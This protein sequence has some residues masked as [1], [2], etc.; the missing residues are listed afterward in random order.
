MKVKEFIKWADEIKAKYGDLFRDGLR[1]HSFP[2]EVY[3]WKEMAMDREGNL[4]F[5]AGDHG[6]SNPEHVVCVVNGVCYSTEH[7]N[8][9]FQGACRTISEYRDTADVIVKVSHGKKV[10]AKE[11]ELRITESVKNATD[12]MIAIKAKDQTVKNKKADK[13]VAAANKE[14]QDIRKWCKFKQT[15]EHIHNKWFDWVERIAHNEDKDKNYTYVCTNGY[16][17]GW[18]CN[19]EDCDFAHYHRKSCRSDQKPKGVSVD[20]KTF[21]K[22]LFDYLKKIADDPKVNRERFCLTAFGYDYGFNLVYDG[23]TNERKYFVDYSL[24]T[25]FPGLSVSRCG[26]ERRTSP[27]HR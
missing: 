17:R 11:T 26:M 2:H 25:K 18:N 10:L 1:I 14:K 12:N 6:S 16:G 27:G 8:G 9:R 21:Y 7:S 3:G 24:V 13:E 23:K 20:K 15:I 19:R 22:L 4:M 5:F